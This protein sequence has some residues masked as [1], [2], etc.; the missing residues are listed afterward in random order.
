MKNLLMKKG[1]LHLKKKLIK[2]KEKKLFL[3]LED[4]APIG[5]INLDKL[6]I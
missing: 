2:F 6:P 5:I 1:G 4:S 3:F